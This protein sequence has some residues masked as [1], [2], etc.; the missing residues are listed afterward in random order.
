MAQA[1]YCDECHKIIGVFCGC[2]MTFAERVRT[3]NVSYEGW[4]PTNQAIEMPSNYPK[5]GK[6]SPHK[7]KGL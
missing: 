3:V 7:P 6:L 4:A 2:D 5:G 1:E